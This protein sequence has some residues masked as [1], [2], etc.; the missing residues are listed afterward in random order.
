MKLLVEPIF[1]S[2][3]AQENVIMGSLPPVGPGSGPQ[4]LPRWLEKTWIAGRRLEKIR[5][6]SDNRSLHR[7][8]KCWRFYIYVQSVINVFGDRCNRFD[9]SHFEQSCCCMQTQ[10][11]PDCESHPQYFNPRF[12]KQ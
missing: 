9:D 1:S 8:S 11:Q 12:S 5:F 4:N 7:A 10:M 2:I 3:H 6:L